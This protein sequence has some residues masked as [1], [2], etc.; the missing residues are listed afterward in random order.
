MNRA[1]LIIATI[2]DLAL[3]ALA[4]GVSGFIVGSGPESM[5]AGLGVQAGLVAFVLLCLLA[6]VAGFVLLRA[7]RPVGGM[8]V[9]WLPP[10]IALFLAVMPPWP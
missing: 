10:L 6:P 7:G 5:R 1:A 4:V 2:A 3:A 8:L 9:A